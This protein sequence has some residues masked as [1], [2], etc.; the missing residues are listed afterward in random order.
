[1]SSTEGTGL[2]SSSTASSAKHRWYPPA[3]LA[4]SSRSCDSSQVVNTSRVPASAG[5]SSNRMTSASQ[6]HW[7]TEGG[8]QTSIRPVSSGSARSYF[9]T[10]AA[11]NGSLIAAPARR[12]PIMSHGIHSRICSDSVMARHTR[13][14]GWG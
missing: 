1:M 13:S 8:S 11:P 5:E 12:S 14:I 9:A 3:A 7:K 6:V 10:S 2:P 4:A